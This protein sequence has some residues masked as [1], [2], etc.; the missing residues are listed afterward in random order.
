MKKIFFIFIVLFS[1]FQTKA[2]V[3]FEDLNYLYNPSFETSTNNVFPSLPGQIHLLENWRSRVLLEI[4]DPTQIIGNCCYH[5]PDWTYSSSTL[6]GFVGA[7]HIGMGTYEMIEQKMKNPIQK[8]RTML[9]TGYVRLDPNS[10]STSPG[11]AQQYIFQLLL[12][13]REMT[14][15]W[16]S[17]DFFTGG[18]AIEY[19][20][21]TD[22]YKQINHVKNAFLMSVNKS[23]I[24]NLDTEWFP[25]SF[26][27]TLDIDNRDW[28][29]INLI[30]SNFSCVLPYFDVDDV[31]II[32]ASCNQCPVAQFVQQELFTHLSGDANGEVVISAQNY[33]IAGSNIAPP[34]NGS[35][36]VFGAVNIHTPQNT[37]GYEANVTFEAGDGI[38]L[39]PGF[40]VDYGSIFETIITPCS[41]SGNDFDQITA[42]AVTG[43]AV[44]NAASGNNDDFVIFTNATDYHV[45]IYKEEGNLLASQT[46]QTTPSSVGSGN[47]VRVPYGTGI[48][49]MDNCYA[50]VFSWFAILSNCLETVLVS[51]NVTV[52][53]D[54]YE[55]KNSEGVSIETTELITAKI[56]P[57]P[58]D[59]LLNIEVEDLEYSEAIILDLSGKTVL[60]YEDSNTASYDVSSLTSGEYFLI[61]RN[62][63][64]ILF[65]SKFIKI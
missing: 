38:I 13:K 7:G 21:C 49:E 9:F 2:Q 41:M 31:S 44:G 46:G 63:E 27:F 65:T 37:V 3:T 50:E 12:A 6:P 19:S 8:E 56:Y 26:E 54:C 17:D 57:N 32:P 35:G 45:E 16:E 14:Y 58:V 30:N 52:L 42:S 5:S 1:F 33:V 64:K 61:L 62:N 47:E 43:M 39:K 25:I 51:G 20:N 11:S 10:F 22:D 23:D 15:E 18:H 29:G 59:N 24:L 48:W 4:D 34:I 28:M 53:G 40:T 55:F 36:P 60:K